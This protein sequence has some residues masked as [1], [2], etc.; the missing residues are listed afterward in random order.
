V[1]VGDITT[2]PEL[3]VVK[4]LPL[5]IG[6]GLRPRALARDVDHFETIPVVTSSTLDHLNRTP[7]SK[8]P[9]LDVMYPRTNDDGSP[10]RDRTPTRFLT[11]RGGQFEV[12]P[13]TPVIA[14]AQGT[15]RRVASDNHGRIVEVAHGG[16][17]VTTYRHLATTVVKVGQRVGPS[18]TLGLVGVDPVEGFVPH[19]HTEG[20]ID[21]KLLDMGPLFALAPAVE[22][23][24]EIGLIPV[25]E[26]AAIQAALEEGARSRGVAMVV[27][28][29]LF[30]LWWFNKRR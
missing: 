11:S 20:R 26:K 10:S 12:R 9:G 14:W 3:R 28:L 2:V 24:S 4:P 6:S 8:V 17:F 25:L 16:G 22:A 23:D 29:G 21:G 5:L 18:Q 30:L 7:P 19:L 1:S 27:L 13:G 15:V